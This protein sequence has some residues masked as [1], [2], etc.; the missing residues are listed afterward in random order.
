MHVIEKTFQ[1]ADEAHAFIVFMVTA[2][3]KPGVFCA[4]LE[5]HGSGCGLNL[6]L[7]L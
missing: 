5:S 1:L 6:L 7:G 3:Q 4:T 2:Y